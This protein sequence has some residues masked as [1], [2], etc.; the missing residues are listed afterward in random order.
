M[1]NILKALAWA[2]VILA[3]AFVM[4]AQ[5]MSD[6]ASL[7]VVAGLSGAAMGSLNSDFSCGRRCLL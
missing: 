5:G 2:G 4:Q 6:S 3:S 7:G 1:N